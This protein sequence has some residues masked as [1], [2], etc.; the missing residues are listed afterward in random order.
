MRQKLVSF[1]TSVGFGNLL[2]AMIFVL[3]ALN[4]YGNGQ[5]LESVRKGE[6]PPMSSTHTVTVGAASITFTI[7]TPWES[8]DNGDGGTLMG[9]HFTQ[10]EA[11][12]ARA[13]TELGGS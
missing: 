11:A 5:I 6:S 8:S 3:C 2:L 10:V 9:R 1:L 13:R 4:L 7:T 12:K